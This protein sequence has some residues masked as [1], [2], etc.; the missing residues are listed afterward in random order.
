[1]TLGDGVSLHE[2]DVIDEHDTAEKHR[3]V[4]GWTWIGTTSKR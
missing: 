1:L 3:A 4:R 2:S